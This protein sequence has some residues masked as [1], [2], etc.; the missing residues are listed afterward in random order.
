M[1]RYIPANLTIRY[2]HGKVF[3]LCTAISLPTKKRSYHVSVYSV[4]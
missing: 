4:S 3:H 2:I 1:N